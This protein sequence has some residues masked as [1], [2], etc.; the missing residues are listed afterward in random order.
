M[1]K[2]VAFWRNNLDEFA[3]RCDALDIYTAQSDMDAVL[4]MWEGN[5]IALY[6]SGAIL[7]LPIERAVILC[8]ELQ[9]FI[10]DVQELQRMQIKFKGLKSL[11]R[12]EQDAQQ[13]KNYSLSVL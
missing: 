4:Y 1:A 12:S 3:N 9:A 8:D 11:K 6:Y 5:D 2:K 7:R 10:S 13:R